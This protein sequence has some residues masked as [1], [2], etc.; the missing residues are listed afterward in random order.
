MGDDSK[1]IMRRED[2]KNYKRRARFELW[3]LYPGGMRLISRHR[4]ERI[5]EFNA[6]KMEYRLDVPSSWKFCINDRKF[7]TD[8][9]NP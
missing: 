9:R 1:K 3:C 5:A 4:I 8:F 6:M 2:M 7:C